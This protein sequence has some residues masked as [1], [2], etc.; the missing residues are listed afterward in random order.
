[1]GRK[2][3][4]VKTCYSQLIGK[5]STLV[6]SVYLYTCYPHGC[7]EKVA[8]RTLQFCSLCYGFPQVAGNTDSAKTVT[9]AT[10]SKNDDLLL[11]SMHT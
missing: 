1:M 9:L 10:K 3:Y 4:A 11:A 8:Q 2:A 6:S 7:S 5:Y